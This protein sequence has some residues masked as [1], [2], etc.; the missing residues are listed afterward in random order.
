MRSTVLSFC[1]LIISSLNLFSQDFK[2]VPEPE[3]NKENLQIAEGF[4]KSYFNKAKTGEYYQFQN[5]AI[6][7]LKN[8]LTKENQKAIYQQLKSQFGDYKDLAYSE[9]YM[10][11]NSSAIQLF[12]FKS[13]FSGTKEK[14]EIR[15][16]LNGDKKIAGFWIKPWDDVLK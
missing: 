11:G 10:T 5:E 4:V 13:D 16:V 7:A 9:T 14:L 3:V 2:K 12:R 15:V 1:I 6:D 8:Q